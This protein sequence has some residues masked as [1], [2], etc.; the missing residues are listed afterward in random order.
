MRR[1][2]EQTLQFAVWRIGVST[3]NSHNLSV[4]AYYFFTAT[5]ILY[6]P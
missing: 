2:G 4:H 6:A 3:E 1:G 5:I